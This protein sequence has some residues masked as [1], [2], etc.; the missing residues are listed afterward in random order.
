MI[1]TYI[2][3]LFTFAGMGLVVHLV[4]SSLDF[5][6]GIMRTKSLWLVISLVRKFEYYWTLLF[7]NIGVSCVFGM[8]GDLHLC[9]FWAHLW[10]HPKPSHVQSQPKQQP[11][12]LL[13]PTAREPICG[14]GV[15]YWVSE[16]LL[17]DL[18]LSDALAAW[19]DQNHVP[20]PKLLLLLSCDGGGH[21]ELVLSPLSLYQ[22][23]V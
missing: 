13:L 18:H 3:L 17:L 16:R 6:L 23:L 8:L 4:V 22:G 7:F 11:N 20:R 12:H 9:H 10:H 19:E 2:L 1:G 5:W 21:W 15:L 14:W